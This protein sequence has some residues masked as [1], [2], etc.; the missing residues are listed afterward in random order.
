VIKT[1]RSARLNSLALFV[2][3]DLVSNP[4]APSPSWMTPNTAP[5]KIFR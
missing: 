1:E 3:L 2:M 4:L 5:I